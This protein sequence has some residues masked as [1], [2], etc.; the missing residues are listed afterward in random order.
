MV[1]IGPSKRRPLS[2]PRD[3]DML[4]MMMVVLMAFILYMFD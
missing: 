2:A 1:M 3:D 4:M